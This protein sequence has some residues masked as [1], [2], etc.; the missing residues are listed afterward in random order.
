MIVHDE[1]AF[2]GGTALATLQEACGRV[3]LDPVGAELV[4][5]G[6]NA[7]F[8]LKD[9]PYVVRIAR[10]GEPGRVQTEVRVARWLADSGFPA[11]RLA[12]VGHVTQADA[13][14]G[15]E[16]CHPRRVRAPCGRPAKSRRA[17]QVARFLA[18]PKRLRRLLDEG[19]DLRLLLV[20][21]KSPDE[22]ADVLE[23]PL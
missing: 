4:R 3:G 1:S 17:A 21:L 13:E 22:A 9:Q 12:D 2:T 23:R 15:R 8:R 10:A 20:R 11:T 18:E 19:P 5:F 14:R 16:R 6:Q 7:I